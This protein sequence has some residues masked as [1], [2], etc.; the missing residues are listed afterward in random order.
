M[1]GSGDAFRRSDLFNRGRDAG[2]TSDSQQLNVT[3]AEVAGFA[4]IVG[5]FAIAILYKARHARK[6]APGE[7]DLWHQDPFL[8][9]PEMVLALVPQEAL[10]SAFETEVVT[11]R[12]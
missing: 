12:R 7:A 3:N 6:L 5:L 8:E 9:H 2:L 11:P 4:A 1:N 10:S